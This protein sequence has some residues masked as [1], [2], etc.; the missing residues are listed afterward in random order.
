MCVQSF[1]MVNIDVPAGVG[2]PPHSTHNQCPS[3]Y[4]QAVLNPLAQPLEAGWLGQLG[5]PQHI[6][7]F[8]VNLGTL[9]TC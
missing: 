4:I 1:H 3:L 6:L 7:S 2:P 9:N 8:F 5:L